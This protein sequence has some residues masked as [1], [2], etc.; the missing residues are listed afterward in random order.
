[1]FLS[2]QTSARKA[3]RLIEPVPL[4]VDM[5]EATGQYPRERYYDL[6]LWEWVVQ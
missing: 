6:L 5:L 4:S 2:Q 3:S 1:M